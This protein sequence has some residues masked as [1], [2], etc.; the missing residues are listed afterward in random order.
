VNPDEPHLATE[1]PLPQWKLP[2]GVTR[3]LWEYVH[4]RSMACEYDTYFANYELFD[5]DEQVIARH[6]RTPGLV[7]DLGC[8]TGR[9]LVPLCRR[10]FR[11]L[12]IDLSENMLA[13]VREK[14]AR[15]NLP[16][17]C[18]RAN[19][20][21]LDLPENSVDYAI[22]L[23]STL[24]MI[25][26]RANRQRVLEATRRMLKPGGVFVLHVHNYWWNL[27][28][29]RG[30]WRLASNYFRAKAIGDVE[31]GDRYFNYRGVHNMFLHVFTRC[32]VVKSLRMAG[33]EI[34]EIIPLE[35]RRKRAL[36]IPWLLSSL[37]ATGWIVVSEKRE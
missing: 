21:E 12:A 35:A 10:G 24:G 8:G 33:F 11:G 32:E 13:V 20:V 3:G 5:F 23:F 1:A 7:A 16:I 29:P 14:A 22:C 18:L 2:A 36:P 27:Y 17:E 6:L 15:E 28:D 9:A 26:G 37:R 25:Q 34:R 31:P 4:S 30:P 19:L